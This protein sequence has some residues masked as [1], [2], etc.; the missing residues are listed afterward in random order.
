LFKL[1]F[2]IKKETEIVSAT[3]KFILLL[4]RQFSKACIVQSQKESVERGRSNYWNCS[5]L[6]LKNIKKRNCIRK[7]FS[8]K[9]V[10][11]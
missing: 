8:K 4:K 3:N 11:F 7:L 6:V 9:R 10:P 5:S 1:N 2:F